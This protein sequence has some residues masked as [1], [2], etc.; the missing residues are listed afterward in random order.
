M[1]LG[2]NNITV[3]TLSVKRGSRLKSED[4]EYYLRGVREVE[5][6]LEL[7]AQILHEAGFI[8]YYVYRQKHQMGSFENTGWCRPGLHSMYN[9]RIMEE[10]Q[11]IIG[12]GAGAIGKRFYKDNNRLERIPNINDYRMYVDRIEDIIARKRR[13]FD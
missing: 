4:P 3:H 9:V 13:Y 1:E 2:A 7:A 12:L 10:M 6:M 5:N 8:P 11:T